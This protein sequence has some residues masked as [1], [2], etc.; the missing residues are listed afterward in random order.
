[1]AIRWQIYS[2]ISQYYFNV[3]TLHPW[4]NVKM[5]VVAIYLISRSKYHHQKVFT[6]RCPFCRYTYVSGLWKREKWLSV[7]TG[8]L[9]LIVQELASGG[10]CHPH[11]GLYKVFVITILDRTCQNIK[12]WPS[13]SLQ[14]VCHS[15][16][17]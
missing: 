13:Y 6:F 17:Y 7:N 9:L 16:V 10:F 5:E 1:M 11:K 3:M 2:A 12:H 15:Q 14:H 4:V 8:T